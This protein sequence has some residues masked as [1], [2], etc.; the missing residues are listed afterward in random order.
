MYSCFKAIIICYLLKLYFF[1]IALF[2]AFC[3]AL[4]FILQFQ[5]PPG[6]SVA[7][8]KDVPINIEDKMKENTEH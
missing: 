3:W 2:S 1:V 4:L 7:K 8:M 5:F 6:S